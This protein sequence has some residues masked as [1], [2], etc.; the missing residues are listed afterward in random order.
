MAQLESKDKQWGSVAGS[1]MHTYSPLAE[2]LAVGSQTEV[3]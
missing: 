1:P 3:G 2:G